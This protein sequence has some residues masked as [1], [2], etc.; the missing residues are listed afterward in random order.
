M[1]HLPNS[2]A[3]FHKFKCGI[4]SMYI[5]LEHDITTGKVMRCW[6]IKTIYFC[7]GTEMY[8]TVYNGAF[9]HVER[10]IFPVFCRV[11]VCYM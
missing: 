2:V 10:I 4:K 1:Y 9:T 8:Q 6:K 3:Y 7:R 11:T 5:W